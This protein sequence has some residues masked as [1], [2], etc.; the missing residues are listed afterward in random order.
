RTRF[1]E[2][3]Q[4]ATA[5]MVEGKEGV[6][7]DGGRLFRMSHSLVLAHEDKTYDGALIAGLSTPWG[8]VKGDDDLGGYHL[9]WTRDMY[10]SATGL[11]AAGDTQTPLRALIYLACTQREDGGFYQNFWI[12]GTPYWTGVQLD[13]VS[14]PIVLAWRLT[15]AGCLEDFD[16]W[17]MVRR[18]AG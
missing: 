12:D 16:P 4:R 18:A 14:F 9:V 11:L 7:G 2:Q 1:V 17:P 6:T 15:K 8:E 5:H 13:E 3:W 10:N